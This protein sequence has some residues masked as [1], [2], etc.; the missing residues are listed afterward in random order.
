MTPRRLRNLVA[1]L[2]RD[3]AFFAAAH[4]EAAKWSQ[5]DELLACLIEVTDRVHLR[6]LSALGA[7]R[8]PKPVTVNRP[9]A[10]SAK[11]AR[12]KATSEDLRRI[13]GGA[14][15]YVATKEVGADA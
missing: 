6:H 3:S 15:R 7:K 14:V 13:F 11:P 8:L 1:G 4:P 2:P 9:K 5:T 12:R 10:P